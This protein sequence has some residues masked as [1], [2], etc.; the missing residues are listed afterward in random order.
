[1]I[2]GMGLNQAQPTKNIEDLTNHGN[3]PQE[4]RILNDPGFVPWCHHR[5]HMV[6]ISK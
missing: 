4:L 3:T 6:S 1:M 5:W 2:S